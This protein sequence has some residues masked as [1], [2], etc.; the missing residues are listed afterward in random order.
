MKTAGYGNRSRPAG[1]RSPAAS[2]R[3]IGLG[4]QA[5]PK[6]DLPNDLFAGFNADPFE[7]LLLAG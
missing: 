3:S 4:E 6:T 2:G 1:A 7:E 5:P